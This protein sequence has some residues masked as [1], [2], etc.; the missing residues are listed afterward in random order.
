MILLTAFD[1]FG[2]NTINSSME[3]LKKLNTREIT[4][5]ILP[6]KFIESF[7]IIKKKIEEVNPSAIMMMGQ[8]GGRTS[9]SFEKAALNLINARI[10]DNNGSKP[11]DEKIFSDTPEGYFSNVDL[12]KMIL[13]LKKIQ[14]PCYISYSAGTYVCNY[15]YYCVLNYIM[16][17]NQS[18]KVIFIHLP[19][20]TEQ[21]TDNPNIASASKDFLTESI[22][23]IID[24][25]RENEV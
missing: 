12:E 19:F 1:V 21:V 2:K 15:L 4:K 13:N 3:V 9:I 5:L 16:S 18:V 22:E 11:T 10:P 24:Y 20:L 14:I 23:K 7:G 6:T 8:A 25:I 17:Y